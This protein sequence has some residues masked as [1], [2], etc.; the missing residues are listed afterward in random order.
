MR[1]RAAQV[2]APPPLGWRGLRVVDGR[3]RRFEQNAVPDRIQRDDIR[4][5]GEQRALIADTPVGIV[6]RNVGTT[7]E[8]RAEM[9]D[10]VR[11]QVVLHAQEQ[12]EPDDGDE[13]GHG[14]KAYRVNANRAHRIHQSNDVRRV[15]AEGVSKA[16]HLSRRRK[17][18][19]RV[20][21][22]RGD[23]PT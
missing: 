9:V 5:A 18:H 13:T 23:A 21:R 3:S 14:G 4:T 17:R 22:R 11:K 20:A 19:R 12:R 6:Q 8:S 2:I 15:D 16:S 7:I 1:R 10:P